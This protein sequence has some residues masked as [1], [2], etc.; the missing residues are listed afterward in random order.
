MLNQNLPRRGFTVVE[1]LVVL[2]IAAIL[3]AVLVPA[4]QSGRESARLNRCKDRLKQ[5]GLALNNYHDTYKTFPPGFVVGGNDVYHGWSWS[6]FVTPFMESNRLYN[7]ILFEAGLQKEYLPAH[8]NLW[9]K[10]GSGS[11]P[12]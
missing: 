1:T 12:S 5:I 4:I 3:C 11:L 2:G 9:V 6:V 7:T 8:Q 10:I